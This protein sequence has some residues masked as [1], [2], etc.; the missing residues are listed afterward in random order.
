MSLRV[1][2]FTSCLTTSSTVSAGSIR[3]RT[4]TPSSVVTLLVGTRVDGLFE[5]IV[6]LDAVCWSD[7]TDEGESK[8][9]QALVAGFQSIDAASANSTAATV[10]SSCNVVLARNRRMDN[11]SY[12]WRLE[13]AHRRWLG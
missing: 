3:V 7:M 5:A 4:V 8:E 9:Q 13:E 2:L 6:E 10:T 12:P 1:G 11:S